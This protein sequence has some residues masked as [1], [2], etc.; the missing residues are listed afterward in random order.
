MTPE[1]LRGEASWLRSDDISERDNEWGRR[2]LCLTAD[3]LDEAAA[4]LERLRADAV[5]YDWIRA[6]G[7]PDQG[8]NY[9][10][11]WTPA[12]YDAAAVRAIAAPTAAPQSP[13]TSPGSTA[14]AG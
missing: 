12:M 4:E 2:R 3:L 10:P 13:P 5:R 7:E 11:D 14:P 9:R 8:L 6:H 1:E